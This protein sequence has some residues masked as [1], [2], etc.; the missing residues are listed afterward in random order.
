MNASDPNDLNDLIAFLDASP[1]PWHPR[2]A[3]APRLMSLVT[4]RGITPALGPLC[5]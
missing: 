3:G 4:E 5:A 1:S 2:L